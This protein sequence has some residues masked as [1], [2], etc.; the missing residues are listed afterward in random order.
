MQQSE[1]INQQYNCRDSDRLK[2]QSRRRHLVATPRFFLRYHVLTK[3]QKYQQQ[4]RCEEVI[5][6]ALQSS[7]SPDY[8][9]KND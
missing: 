9:V 4:F 8:N 5:M 2:K 1:R 7:R 3:N 6:L